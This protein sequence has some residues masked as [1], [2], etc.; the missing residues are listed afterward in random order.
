MT[1]HV[2]AYGTRIEQSIQKV[3]DKHC[4]NISGSQ[5]VPRQDIY[6]T[7]VSLSKH[8]SETRSA[9]LG[10]VVFQQTIDKSADRRLT[11]MQVHAIQWGRT[12]RFNIL[13]LSPF[14]NQNSASDTSMSNDK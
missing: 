8:I 1:G 7:Q 10:V 13:P 3:F 12:V 6:M 14:Q 11:V 9:C 5:N 2:I 4:C